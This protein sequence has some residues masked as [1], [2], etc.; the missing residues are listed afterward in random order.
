MSSKMSRGGSL[1]LV[2][3]VPAVLMLRPGIS[4]A[5]PESGSS[6]SVSSFSFP[7]AEWYLADI[8]VLLLKATLLALLTK[9]PKTEGSSWGLGVGVAC[10]LFLLAL[11]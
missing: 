7:R 8:V 10:G 3:L 1:K 2:V 5:D 6:S 11:E 9:R 4:S